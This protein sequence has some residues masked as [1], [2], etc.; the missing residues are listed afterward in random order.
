M[1]KDKE[2]N[3]KIKKESLSK[4]LEKLETSYEEN[5]SLTDLLRENFDVLESQIKKHRG[6]RFLK[7]NSPNEINMENSFYENLAKLLKE[8]K[9]FY[10]IDINSSTIASIMSRLRKEKKSTL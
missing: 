8:S 3:S 10:G 1:K 6:I 2:N 9:E 7:K 4:K 5:K